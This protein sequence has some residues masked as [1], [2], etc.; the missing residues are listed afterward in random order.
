MKIRPSLKSMFNIEIDEVY[1]MYTVLYLDEN[2]IPEPYN[3]TNADIEVML[4]SQAANYR[5]DLFS[6]LDKN[7]L[8]E[9]YI[10]Y[11]GRRIDKNNYL[12]I[13]G[14]SLFDT[15]KMAKNVLFKYIPLLNL[16]VFTIGFIIYLISHNFF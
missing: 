11:D 10:I 6:F 2:K 3:T 13:I 16:F 7:G 14:F 5:K 8:A 9:L 1:H 12:F 4:K 15:E